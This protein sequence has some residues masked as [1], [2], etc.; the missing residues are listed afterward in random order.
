MT[1]TLA[2]FLAVACALAGAAPA[3]AHKPSDSYLSLRLER[4]RIEGHWD[5]A[6]RDLDVVLDLDRNE[7]GRIDWGEVRTRLEEIDRY[8]IGHLSVATAAPCALEI[9]DHQIDRHS[10][11]AYVVLALGGRCAGR[12]SLSID[13]SLLF[14]V[15][16]QHRGLL[17]LEIVD[18]ANAHVLAAV[19]PAERRQQTFSLGGTSSWTQ[20]FGY[21]RDGITHI[22]TGYD[23]L[24]FLMA[25]LLPAVL[26]RRQGAWTPVASV[27]PAAGSVVKTVT[28]FTLA[29]SATL[30]LATLGVV[31]LPARLTESVIAAS[32]LLTAIDN[33]VP[34]LPSKRWIVAFVF[35]LVHG[36]GFASVLA[37]LDLPRSALALSLVGFNL[38]V[39]TGQLILVA[40]FIPLAYVARRTLL[41]QPVV[42]HGGSVVIA[43]LAA[44]WLID[45]SLNLGIMPF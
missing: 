18:G 15:D 7:D 40:L 24:L 16:A 43:V 9:T 42:L 23:H 13:Y 30:A 38:G 37:D 4:D 3:F 6:L 41:Y 19:F 5:I 34:I 39:E 22:A 35:G 2:T 44:G 29:H 21:L 33:L 45:R 8:A 10:D 27:A 17:K 26:I 20:L 25:L 11:G 32:V 28:A 14:D 1:R 12:G 31:S 36:F